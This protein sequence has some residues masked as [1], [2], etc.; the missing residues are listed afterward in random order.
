MNRVRMWLM[1]SPFGAGTWQ[2]LALAMGMAYVS[3]TVTQFAIGFD[4][5]LWLTGFIAI[6]FV[7]LVFAVIVG[8]RTRRYGAR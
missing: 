5:G 4:L 6:S 8:R 1:W 2:R 3:M 7:G